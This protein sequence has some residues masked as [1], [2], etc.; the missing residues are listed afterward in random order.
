MITK[1]MLSKWW[2]AL[3]LTLPLCL[4][5][6]ACKD[7]GK[8]KAQA[9]P[10]PEVTVAKPTTGNVTVWAQYPGRTQ[11][12]AEVE[13][14]ARVEGFLEKVAFAPSSMVKPGDLLFIIEPAPYQA[15]L[16]QAKAQLAVNQAQ[17]KLAE[18]TL[19]RKQNA[20][21]QRAVSEVEVIEAQAQRQEAVAQ[22]K[23]AQAQVEAAQIKLGYTRITAPIEGLVS[24]NLVDQG[25]LVGASGQATVLTTIRDVNPIY[26]YFNISEADLLRYMR[27]HKLGDGDMS[28]DKNY[29]VQMALSDE[30]GYPHQGTIDYHDNRVDPA[31]GT[32]Q[33][34]GV[35]DNNSAKVPPGMFVK[36]RIPVQ[37]LK[38]ALLVPETATGRDQGGDY[39]LVV[40]DG[41]KV[42]RRAVELGPRHDGKRVIT[43]G[44]KPDDQVIIKGLTKTRAGGTVKAVP[45]GQAKQTQAGGAKAKPAQ[46]GAA[47][48]K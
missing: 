36:V 24:R 35:F 45:E 16:D 7:A 17:L 30:K 20:Y 11:A 31:T 13:V 14:T 4:S 33:L 25:N 1:R 42:E 37:D 40:G 9:P 48:A 39:V 8:G 2:V 26:V 21:K 23:S 32:I 10:P 47:K 38:N 34:R 3:A 15:D 22:V 12:Q 18:A 43:K 19:K 29:V 27:I 46:A 44:V 41:G 5:A 6:V 28:H